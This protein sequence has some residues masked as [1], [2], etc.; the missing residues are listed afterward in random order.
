MAPMTASSPRAP[1]C[2]NV[3]RIPGMK[4][5]GSLAAASSSVSS[6]FLAASSGEAPAMT[7]LYAT[8][9]RYI[10]TSRGSPSAAARRRAAIA[11]SSASSSRLGFSSSSSGSSASFPSASAQSRSASEAASSAWVLL[12]PNSSSTA[13]A[14]RMA[15]AA[16]PHFRFSF[17]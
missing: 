4:P 16:S 12:G 6:T 5:V 3:E 11:A 14:A 9:P 13:M 1:G 15:R 17:L 2:P 7:A 8:W 10:W